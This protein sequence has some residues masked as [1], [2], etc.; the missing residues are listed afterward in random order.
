MEY[1]SMQATTNRV[2]AS[3]PDLG[4]FQVGIICLIEMFINEFVSRGIWSAKLIRFLILTGCGSSRGS[5]YAAEL[6]GA[7]LPPTT[8]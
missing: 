2:L 6:S 3:L 5:A 7:G 1:M 4:L 8:F